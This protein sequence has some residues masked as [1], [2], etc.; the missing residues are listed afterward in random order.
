MALGLLT[1]TADSGSDFFACKISIFY[2]SFELSVICGYRQS[3]WVPAVAFTLI[4][5]FSSTVYCRVFAHY[6]V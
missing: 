3:L 2:M 5:Y 6:G 4:I 1:A